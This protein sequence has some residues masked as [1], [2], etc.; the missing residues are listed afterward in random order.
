MTEM[1][2]WYLRCRNGCIMLTVEQ[3][4][5]RRGFTTAWPATLGCGQH[6]RRIFRESLHLMRERVL[7]IDAPRST[8][9][10]DPVET[11]ELPIR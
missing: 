8:V 1:I 5:T 6:M 11:G 7:L 10:Y 3:V 2:R 9:L 4:G